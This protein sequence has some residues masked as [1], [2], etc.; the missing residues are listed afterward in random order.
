[1]SSRI[2]WP[3]SLNFMLLQLEATKLENIIETQMSDG[4]IK[5]RHIRTAKDAWKGEARFTELDEQL[6]RTIVGKRAVADVPGENAR[7]LVKLMGDDPFYPGYAPRQ[8]QH[9][10]S[11]VEPTSSFIRYFILDEGPLSEGA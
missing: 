3:E 1:M 8:L 11:N 2:E 10:W 5:R 7:R 6:M 4:S 9:T